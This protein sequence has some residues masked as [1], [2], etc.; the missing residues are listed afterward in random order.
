MSFMQLHCPFCEHGHKDPFE[1]LDTNALDSMKCEACSAVF[2]FAIMECE[3]CAHEQTFSWP[4][5]PSSAVLDL[6][7][8]EACGNA[9]RKC[10]ETSE[11]EDDY[12]SP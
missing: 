12:F 9:F 1:V 6:L 10:N 8:C 7:T 4:Q 3:R 5:Q 11:Q 2:W